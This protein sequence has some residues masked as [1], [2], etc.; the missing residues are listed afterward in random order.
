MVRRDESRASSSTDGSEANSNDGYLTIEAV[1]ADQQ[2][3]YERLEIGFHFHPAMPQ[4]LGFDPRI[5]QDEFDPF[6]LDL[7]AYIDLDN[8]T[9]KENG[10]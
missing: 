6:N 2:A 7:N 5:I 8:E 10:P 9:N 3:A 1:T 4:I